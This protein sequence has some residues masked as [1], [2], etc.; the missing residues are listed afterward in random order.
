MNIFS[1]P[2]TP[3]R[4]VAI[5]TP[6]SADGDA[7]G[8]GRKSG[9]HEPG[10]SIQT[11]YADNRSLS[12][13]R[14]ARRFPIALRTQLRRQA[15]GMGFPDTGR[16]FRDRVRGRY[17][18]LAARLDE[19]QKLRRDIR[20]LLLPLEN[21]RLHGHRHTRDRQPPSDTRTDNDGLHTPQQ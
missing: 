1:L 6:L 19:R 9:R 8:A 12:A 17:L 13:R 2:Y 4:V 18:P 3:D 20:P 21:T 10:D 5:G 16:A 14:Y 7:T 11:G 15:A